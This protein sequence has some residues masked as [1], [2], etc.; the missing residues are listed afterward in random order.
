MLEQ[1]VAAARSSADDLTAWR[2]HLHMHPEISFEEVATTEWLASRLEEWGIAYTRPTPTGLVG[3]I[4]GD[5]PGPT[6]AV[7]ADID[8]L[9]ITEEN[10]FSFRSNR[11]GAMHACGHDGHTAI[12][13]GFARFFSKHRDFPGR[14]KLLFQP[15]EEKPPGGAQAF[16]EAGVLDDVDS[17]IGLHLMADIPTGTAGI[18]AGPMIKIEV[19]I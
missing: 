1:L 15:A 4:E 19:I 9:P 17:C 2:R 16:V 7:R 8:A 12:L 13:L 18:T 11:P 5:R 3:L 14:I 10:Q 6:I